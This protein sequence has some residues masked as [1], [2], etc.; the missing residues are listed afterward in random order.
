MIYTFV[1][2]TWLFLSVQLIIAIDKGEHLS[3]AQEVSRP[4]MYFLFVAWSCGGKAWEGN[5]HLLSVCQVHMQCRCFT[6]EHSNNVKEL[7]I[8]CIFKRRD[9]MFWERIKITQLEC[10]TFRWMHSE[11]YSSLNKIWLLYPS[12][13]LCS[14]SKKSCSNWGSQFM[15]KQT[16]IGILIQ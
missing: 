16:R 10:S 14:L 7:G 15:K 8:F 11:L 13:Y 4:C 3:K 12:K 9:V 2:D 1:S 6:C 5:E